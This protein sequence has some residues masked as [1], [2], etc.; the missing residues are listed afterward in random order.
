MPPGHGGAGSVG[1]V[2][3]VVEVGPGRFRVSEM[4][5]GGNGGGFNRVDYRW[6]GNDSA[7]RFLISG[8]STPPPN[9]PPT[10]QPPPPPPL[11]N[12]PYPGEFV[13]VTGEGT[14]Y[15]VGEDG[16]LVPIGSTDVAT[17][18]GYDLSQTKQISA[19]TRNMRFIG[20]VLLGPP[21]PLGTG[22]PAQ[23][24][25]GSLAALLLVGGAGVLAYYAARQRGIG[26]SIANR[27]GSA[28]GFGDGSAHVVRTT[29]PQ[30]GRISFSVPTP[31]S[32][33]FE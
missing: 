16:S 14:I 18:C 33:A 31:R 22:G 24:T 15:V 32:R 13:Q 7:F 9:P 2:A 3:V 20:T 26:L 17:A 28:G 4:N 23:S 10:P 6:V 1:H 21:C 25:G 11:E 5:Y 29:P 8:A 12:N 27:P 30:G 19:E